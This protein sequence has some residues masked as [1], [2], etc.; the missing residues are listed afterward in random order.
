MSATRWIL[1]CIL[2]AV[3]YSPTLSARGADDL[4]TQDLG[5][6]SAGSNARSRTIDSGTTTGGELSSPS[7]SRSSEA[8][9]SAGNESGD[10]AGT[11]PVSTGARQAPS[12]R[13]SVGWQ[14]LLP[15]SIQ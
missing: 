12:P 7:T 14:S 1:G 3:I 13:S 8:P 15:G 10:G 4:G 11:L 2:A 9:A 5:Q 6:H